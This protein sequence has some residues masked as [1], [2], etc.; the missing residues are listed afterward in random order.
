MLPLIGAILVA[1]LLGSLHCAG[2]CGAFLALSISPPGQVRTPSW[3]LHASYHLGR[4]CTYLTFGV[5]AGALGG[6]LDLAGDMAGIQ[7]AAAVG[8]G[9]VMVV[10]G[11]TCV[12]GACGVRLPRVP[13]PRALESVVV[14]GHALADRF[15]PSARAV[16][17]GAVTTLLPCG[18]LYAFVATAAG[19]AHPASGA[20]AMLA[21]WLGTLPALAALGIGLQRGLGSFRRILP[22][23][24]SIMLVGVGLATLAGRVRFIQSDGVRSEVVCHPVR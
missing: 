14:R 11:G 17:I 19:T 23:A 22:V 12:A 6:A 13:A 5:I 16:V 21:F 18:W 10:F 8:A 1:S 24:T 4:L 3:R 7:Q 2:M 20:L 9:I 15:G